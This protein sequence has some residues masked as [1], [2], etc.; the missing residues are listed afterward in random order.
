MDVKLAPAT[1]E[2]LNHILSVADTSSDKVTY[3][4]T[5][6]VAIAIKLFELSCMTEHMHDKAVDVFRLARDSWLKQKGENDGAA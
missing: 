3:S 5:D 4:E 2:L 1:V 6:I